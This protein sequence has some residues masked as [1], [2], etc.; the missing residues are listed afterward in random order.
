MVSRRSRVLIALFGFIPY[1][2]TI[3]LPPIPTFW[4]E[5]AAVLLAAAW[6]VSVG[7]IALRRPA[8]IGAAPR[9]PAQ[10]RMPVS[11][12]AYAA[13]AVVLVLQVMAQQPIFRGAPILVICTLVMASLVS[14]T[15]ARTRASDASTELVDAWAWGLIAAV[16][17][18]LVAVLMDRQGMHVYIDRIGWRAP[19]GRAEGL[20]GQYNQLAVFAAIGNVAAFYLWWRGKLWRPAQVAMILITA[21]IVASTASRAGALIWLGGTALAALSV[22]GDI[23]RRSAWTL[24]ALGG[25][26]FLGVQ[27]AWRVFNEDLI[28][29]GTTVL[30]TDTQGRV[31]LLRDSW[32][33]ML[34]HPLAGV[35]YGNFMGARWTE[36]SNSLLEP[37]AHQAHNL[38]AQLVVEL[39]I[40][41]ALLVLV[42]LGW[43]LVRCVV[44]VTRRGVS[45]DQFFVAAFALMLTAYALVEFP[46]WFTYFLLPFALAMGWVD[47]KDLRLKATG[48]PASIQAVA[49]SLGVAG[50]IALCLDYH[51][52]EDLY[53]SLELQ[54]REGQGA[55]VRIP[56]EAAARISA[57]SAFD[58]YANLMYSRTLPPDG[59]FTGYKLDVTDKAMR[60]VTNQETIGR[61]VA[62]LVVGGNTAEATRLLKQ[63]E[64]NATL[65]RNTRAVLREL[66]KQHPAILDFLNALPALPPSPTDDKPAP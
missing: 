11:V 27:W 62:L 58:L 18:N 64:R 28:A 38:I 65:A 30:R 36:L 55:E 50:C 22:R 10:F 32:E 24:L 31:E 20:I 39:G 33:L 43:G 59:L 1:V 35:G 9:E 44:V 26:A 53:S 54:Q 25:I 17:V 40:P 41:G 19:P 49:C 5:M 57:F 37:T 47:Q 12:L 52:S 48:M 61:D 66:G 29:T 2:S 7:G 45:P 63:T 34:K 42:P 51:R 3:K 6:I 14:L 4:A 46:F 23:R 16:V 8:T 60:S 56:I 21:L 13:M 15:A